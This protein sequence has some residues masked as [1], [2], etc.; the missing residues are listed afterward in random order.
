M[1]VSK[2][3]KKLKVIATM[4]KKFQ[5]LLIIVGFAFAA[6]SATAQT[7]ATVA[8]MPEGMITFPITHGAMNYLSLPLTNDPIY[9]GSVS[10]ISS[11]SIS[12]GDS[13]APFTSSLLTAGSPYFVK[14]MSGN[15]VG[16]VLLVT[17]NTTSSL[18]L[19]TSDHNSGTAI[20][21]DT[22]GFNVQTGDT[23]EIFP[24]D[25]LAS[26]LGA[27]TA[28]SP[29]LLTGGM[30]VVVADTVSFPTR[31]SLPPATY[32]F[33]TTSGYWVQFGSTANANNTVIY[34]YAAFAV[35]RRNNHPD[36]T[37]VLGGRV[38]EVA[39]D[40]KVAGNDTTFTSSHYA[41]DIKLS[42]LQFGA[43]WVNGNSITSTD[44]LNVWNPSEGRF[45][46]YYQKPDATW[47]RFPTPRPTRAISPSPPARSSPSPSGNQ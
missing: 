42:Q 46:G 23:F 45:D 8:S 33:N 5:I 24:G 37:L 10:A 30:N 26:V 44:V 13:P 28:Q 43:T 25:T 11:T 1:V 29:L 40:I 7:A 16:R 20:F 15:E 47:R 21:L 3:E 32:Y 18:T 17:A 41:T 2:M 35:T 14:F 31:T 39:A 38:A 22:A 36:T 19:D 12:V 6:I 4:S 27:G 9:T 34:P